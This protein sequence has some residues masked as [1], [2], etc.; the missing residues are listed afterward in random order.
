M[1]RQCLTLTHQQMTPPPAP[2]AHNPYHEGD[3]I[4][5]M[6]TPPERTSKL[7]PRWKGPFVIQRVPNA[8]QV[9]Y[10]DDM[11]WR[12]VHVNHVKPAKTPAGG[13]PVPISPPA[14]PSPPPMYLS[15]NLTWRKPAKPPQSAAPTG[16]SPQPAAPVAEPAQPATSSHPVSPPPSRPTTR[17][18]ANQNSAPSLCSSGHRPLLGEAMRIR[19]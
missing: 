2:E 3:L 14:P 12:T 13:F 1:V 9:T 19:G 4:F 10:E 17:S 5:V 16:G 18:S 6:T 7:A 11:V 15:R 8:Y